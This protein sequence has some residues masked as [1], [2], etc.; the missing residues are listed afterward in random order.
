MHR[1]LVTLV[2]FVSLAACSDDAPTTVDATGIDASS[3]E[4]RCLV[5]SDYGN[6]GT[7]TGATS[8][9]M[10]P[11]SL[12]I[13]LDEGPPRDSFFINLKNAVPAGTY[14]ITGDNANASTCSVC[15]NIIADIVAMQGPTKFYFATSG[16]VTLTAT[17][18]P[19]GTLT[20]VGFVET[21]VGGA[22]T[23]SGCIS[24]IAAMSFG[25]M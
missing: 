14:E 3:D 20:N 6:L 7:L 10:S 22:P 11:T 18:P 5:P 12:T 4:A 21:T 13:V 17:E 8:A 23:N 25:P 1:Q 9:G 19:A 24:Q 2:I 15:V 16:S